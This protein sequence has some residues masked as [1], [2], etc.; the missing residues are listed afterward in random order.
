ME[1]INTPNVEMDPPSMGVVPKK[2]SE[3]KPAEKEEKKSKEEKNLRFMTKSRNGNKIR[4]MGPSEKNR[5]Q[6]RDADR[7][8]LSSLGKG[9]E[10]RAKTTGAFGTPG[11]ITSKKK[12]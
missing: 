9:N 11:K 8:F 6:R 1:K 3:E 12:K 4:I 2:E 5:R 7:R 10:E